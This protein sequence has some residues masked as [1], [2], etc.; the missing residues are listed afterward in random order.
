MSVAF[1]RR[2]R[3]LPFENLP[4]H[5][6][7]RRR[8]SIGGNWKELNENLAPLR[9]YLERQ[10]GRPWG[11]VY[12]EIAAHLRADNTVQQHVRDH[13]RDFVAVAPRR[14]AGLYANRV[15]GLWHQPLYVDEKDGILKRTDRLPEEKARRRARRNP[16]PRPIDR[17][18]LA[19]DRELR[20]ID[21]FWYELRLA[22]MPD[23]DYRTVVER[24][25]IPL[26][27]YRRRS[28]LVEVEVTVRRLVGPA[29]RDVAT[30]LLVEAGPETDEPRAW[31]E[32]RRRHADR[33]YAVAKR[34]LGKAELRRHALHDD[35]PQEEHLSFPHQRADRGFGPV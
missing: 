9:R 2:G 21:G 33:R 18:A 16:P 4:Q 35:A 19:A 17:V 13:L 34:R 28:P 14:H 29:I 25:Q 26:K 20:R 32:Y 24:R 3:P 12:S 8:H 6:S 1:T 15:S 11:K 30:G 22:P 10:V 23:P 27:P 7:M 5:E 31:S